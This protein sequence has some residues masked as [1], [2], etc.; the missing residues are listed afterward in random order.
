MIFPCHLYKCP[1]PHDRYGIKYRY[2]GCAD[3]EQFEE[4]TAQ[5]WHATFEAAAGK[6][7]PVDDVSPPTRAEMEQKAKELGLRGIHLMKDDTLAKKIA[8]AL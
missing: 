1:G 8:E 3:E 2:I 4:L 6:D 7:K 5:E